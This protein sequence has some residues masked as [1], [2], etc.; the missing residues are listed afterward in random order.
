M[1]S[2]Q[3]LITTVLRPWASSVEAESRA[4]MMRCPCG[5]EQSVWDW[6]GVRWKA[7]GKPKRLLKCPSCGERTWHTVYHKPTRGNAV[8]GTS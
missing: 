8:S 5:Y 1:T 2:V 3:R 7:A 4:W 6:G